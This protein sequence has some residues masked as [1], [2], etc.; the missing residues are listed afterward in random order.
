MATML[1]APRQ[2]THRWHLAAL[3]SGV[4][5]A[6]CGVLEKEAEV[7]LEDRCL[8]WTEGFVPLKKDDVYLSVERFEG[9]DSE[10]IPIPERSEWMF[11]A[12]QVSSTVVEIHGCVPRTTRDISTNRGTF[13]QRWDEWSWNSTWEF[14]G[15]FSSPRKL[16]VGS[17]L[18]G[19]Q[20]MTGV[21]VHRVL[22]ESSCRSGRCGAR[23]LWDVEF[24]KRGISHATVNAYDIGSLNAKGLVVDD[25]EDHQLTFDFD[26]S[27]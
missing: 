10:D 12:Q 16:W 17:D 23:R 19:A 15:N 22:V 8:S 4:M 13:D 25:E 9:S 5:L 21:F 20:R 3:L 6:S 18:P 1:H 24:E 27:W 26:V 14:T 2:T 11:A 7:D